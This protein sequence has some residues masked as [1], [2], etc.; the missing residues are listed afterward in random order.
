MAERGVIVFHDELNPALA[1][2]FYSQVP[3]G[4]TLIT[5]GPGEPVPPVEEAD[6]LLVAADL[7]PAEEIRR[8]KRAHL[9]QKVGVGYDNI[10]LGAAA[11]M[12]IPVA[13]AAGA[14]SIAVAEHAILMMM[15]LQRRLVPIH[16]ATMAG[17]WRMWAHRHE[18]FELADK[19]V[20]LVG[21]GSIGREVAS[22]VQAFGCEVAYYDAFRL[23][24]ETERAL[25]LT[26]MPLEQLLRTSDIISLH[27]PLSDSTR[28]LIN[29]ERIELMKPG[30]ILINT[31]R[32]PVVN[33]SDLAEALRTGRI[34][35]AGLD[36]HDPEPPQPG[37][38]LYGLPNVI[39][40]PHAAAG[41][42]DTQRRVVKAA[43][44]NVIRVANGDAPLN[45][46]KR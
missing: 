46:V 3:P 1:D 40:T 31:A 5:R 23:P 44:A 6:Y 20:G 2:V 18:C 34:F 41:T 32:G 24:E 26:F 39:L 42:R 43:M 14:N 22:R 19:Q 16:N 33:V 45:Q 25:K 7:L 17:E 38:P 4:F 27:V 36:V 30:A 21:L 28:H 11:E 9:I 15:A 10:H 13:I 37:Y 8:L 12:G 35:G 29:R